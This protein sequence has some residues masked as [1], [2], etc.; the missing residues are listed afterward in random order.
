MARGSWHAAGG[1]C[2]A[3]GFRRHVRIEHFD[4]ATHMSW[5]ATKPA[6]PRGDPTTATILTWIFPGAGHLYLGAPLFGLL[7]FVV[8]GGLYLLGLRLSNGMVFEFLDA[9]LRVPFAGALTPEVGN[10]SGLVWQMRQYGF[11]P[12]T[13]RP[14]PEHIHLGAWLTASS[15][16]L[17]ACLM[18]HANFFARVPEG[19]RTSQPS[20]GLHVLAAWLVPGLGHWLQGRRARGLA[21][22]GVL[23]GMLVLGTWL[24]EGSNLDRE[25]HFYYWSGQFLAG[26]P[27]MVL[28]AAHGHAPV[29]HDIEYA[30]AGLVFAC[31]AGMLN[32]LAM[33]DVQTFSEARAI[34]AIED[35]RAE[36]AATP[37]PS[38]TTA[39]KAPG[40]SS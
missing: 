15:G 20:P 2:R 23:V 29:T 24:A 11:G 37:V 4:S 25:R 6:T 12:P 16:M 7:S 32:V 38:A 3:T 30:D 13:P 8:L 28:E 22:F 27:T 21:V 1:K 36:A 39:P 9:D 35:P 40:A 17:N 31:L 26:I 5:S 18:V 14:W 33:L 34:A 19:R 10:L